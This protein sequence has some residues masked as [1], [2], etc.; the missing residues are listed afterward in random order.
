MICGQIFKIE[1]LKGFGF[2]R[3]KVV[4]DPIMGWVVED[5]AGGLSTV[6]SEKV[7]FGVIKLMK[8]KHTTRIAYPEV[9]EAEE[10]EQAA[11]E[12]A[13]EAPFNYVYDEAYYP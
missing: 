13:A 7:A 3:W 8:Q 11:V 12:L 5:T 4:Y 1:A 9:V 10:Q 2:Y 6:V